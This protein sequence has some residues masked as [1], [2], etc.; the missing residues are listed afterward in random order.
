MD[1]LAFLLKFFGGPLID[2]SKKIIIKGDV[3]SH[4]DKIISNPE[5]T[6]EFFKEIEKYKNEENLPFQI[7]H[8]D[9]TKPYEDYKKISKEGSRNLK[10][11]KEILPIEEI[12]CILMARRIKLAFDK[13]DKKLAKVL[14]DQLDKNYPKKGR[15]VANL[16]N[17]GYFDELILPMIELCK[18][19]HKENYKEKFREFYQNILTFLPMAIFVNNET[20]EDYL[21][22][23]INRRLKL[24]GIPFIKIHSMG[25]ENIEK[26][27][28]V[29]ESFKESGNFDIN[30]QR[31]ITSTGIEAQ[32]LELIL[33]DE[34]SKPKRKTTS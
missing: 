2:Q 33:R 13:K 28:K 15:K 21:E 34:K 4:G 20:S 31:F 27:E 25:K 7:I 1:F 29:L 24:K 26:V 23:E 9:L 3:I 6:L 30:D 32:D 10:L 17:A 22:K 8:K 14:Y 18:T 11:L 5:K 12:E 19:K 16:I